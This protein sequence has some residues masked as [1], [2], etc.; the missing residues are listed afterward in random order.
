MTHDVAVLPAVVSSD[1]P[2]MHDSVVR[3]QAYRALMD[4]KDPA[5]YSLLISIL[6]L[7][8]SIPSAL[9]AWKS[10]NWERDSANS[11]RRSAEA[12]ERANLLAERATARQA[13]GAHEG[14][15]LGTVRESSPQ[16]RR[17]VVWQIEHP[18]GSRYVLR[19]VG[20]DIAEHVS[21][22]IEQ[23]SGLVRNLPSDA[24][25]RPGEGVDFLVA[26]AWGRPVP[27]QLYLKWNDMRDFVAIPMPG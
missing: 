6:A 24:V 8:L 13:S 27:N 10:L 22:D 20:T 1:T 2:T 3:T 9:L 16:T 4:W 19:N 14:R 11:A 23:S 7:L 17:N 21:G 12:A 5:W 25:I 15:E 26:G 18:S